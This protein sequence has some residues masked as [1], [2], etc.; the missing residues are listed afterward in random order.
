MDGHFSST[1]IEKFILQDQREILETDEL[2][3]NKFNF[4]SVHL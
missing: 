4:T 3:G 1:V 2:S